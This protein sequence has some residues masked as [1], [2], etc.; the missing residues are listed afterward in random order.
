MERRKRRSA[1]SVGSFGLGITVVN[2]F[3]GYDPHGC[4]KCSAERICRFTAGTMDHLEIADG[5]P[6]IFPPRIV[7]LLMT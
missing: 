4:G 3:L 1:T 5:M 6:C 7:L 2:F